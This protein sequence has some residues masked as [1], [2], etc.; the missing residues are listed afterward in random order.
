MAGNAIALQPPKAYDLLAAQPASS[1]GLSESEKSNIVV[2]AVA[3][4]DGSNH[5]LSRFGDPVWDFRP[6]FGN[7]MWPMVRNTFLAWRGL[8]ARAGRRLQG[9]SVCMV[10]ARLAR[11]QASG[12]N[13]HLPDCHRIRDSD[14]A[15]ADCVE[16]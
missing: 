13:G 15:L 12:G 16:H 14:D 11:L 10:Q 5:V 8:L 1:K 4:M 7:P 3:D 6:Y 9:C 2:S